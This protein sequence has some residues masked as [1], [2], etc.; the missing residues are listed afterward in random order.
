MSD[1]D[2]RSTAPAAPKLPE[3]E[4][5]PPED[6]LDGVPSKEEIVEQAETAEK[7]VEEQP[8]PEQLLGRDRR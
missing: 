3:V 2:N 8:S 1:S 6:V 7:I 5:P 4:S